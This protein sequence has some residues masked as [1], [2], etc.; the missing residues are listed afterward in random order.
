MVFLRLL[1][2]YGTVEFREFVEFGELGIL[3][4]CRVVEKQIGKFA[5]TGIGV[6]CEVSG[7]RE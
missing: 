1:Y 3:A 7:F 6:R 2:I 4:Q 5:E